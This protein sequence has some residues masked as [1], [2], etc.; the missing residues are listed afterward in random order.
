MFAFWR[1]INYDLF[2]CS[3]ELHNLES[4]KTVHFS[5]SH[6][7][8]LRKL[9]FILDYSQLTMLRWSQGDSERAQPH[10]YESL[11]WTVSEP[12]SLT[13]K[14]SLQRGQAWWARNLWVAELIKRKERDRFR[15]RRQ[16]RA[17]SAPCW[18]L[19]DASCREQAAHRGTETPKAEGRLQ[20]PLPPCALWRQDVSSPSRKTVDRNT[21]L[22]SYC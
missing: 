9:N 8:F 1:L 3:L 11:R 5:I 13:R 12:W 14:L 16:K 20:A 17:G 15:H 21:G 6:V 7:S 19:A 2:L 4:V 22:L 10:I 18:S